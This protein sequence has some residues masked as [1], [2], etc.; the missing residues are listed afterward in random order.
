MPYKVVG[1]KVMHFKNGKWAVKQ[2]CKDASN[3]KKAM[4]L[5]MGLEKGTIKTKKKNNLKIK[6]KINL[7]IKKV[8]K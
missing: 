8:K 1:N 6:K 7:K 5:L 3:A 4:A 2:V